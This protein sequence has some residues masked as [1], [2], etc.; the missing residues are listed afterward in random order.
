MNQSARQRLPTSRPAVR[1]KALGPTGGG[2][3]IARRL[4][5]PKGWTP[6]P[7]PAGIRDNPGSW[8]SQNPSRLYFGGTSEAPRRDFISAS[9]GG[10]GA[11]VS[12]GRGFLNRAASGFAGDGF[13]PRDSR[14]SEAL[15]KERAADCLPLGGPPRWG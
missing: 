2:R 3:L 12:R 8:E 6:R 11:A 4:Y 14:K 13:L 10:G 5:P 1:S 9:G 7:L 15:R